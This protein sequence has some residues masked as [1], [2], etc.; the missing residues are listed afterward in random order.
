MTSQG[1][2]DTVKRSR[3]SILYVV[4]GII[5]MWLAYSLV[6][7]ILSTL[8]RTERGGY[9]PSPFQWV[10]TESAHAAYYSESEQDTFLEYK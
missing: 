9:T 7:W 2:E 1:D 6:N 5:V 10:F 8:E 3:T 4:I